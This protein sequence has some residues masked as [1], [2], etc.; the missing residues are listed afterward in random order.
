MLDANLKKQLDTYL[1][2]IK[3]PIELSVSVDESSM[4]WRRKSLRCRRTSA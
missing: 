1:Q 2:N 3:T 4:S